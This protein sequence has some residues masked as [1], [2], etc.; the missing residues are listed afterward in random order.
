[1]RPYH[2]QRQLSQEQSALHVQAL[3]P[4]CEF[5]RRAVRRDDG[6]FVGEERWSVRHCSSDPEMRGSLCDPP[7]LHGPLLPAHPFYVFSLPHFLSL[8]LS[9]SHPHTESRPLKDYG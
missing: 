1:M 3:S 9:L 8:S 2:N 7:S 5:R 4:V 6:T